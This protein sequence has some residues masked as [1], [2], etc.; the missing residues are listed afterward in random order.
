METEG[1]LLV[2]GRNA[3]FS[4]FDVAS[5]AAMRHLVTF[6]LGTNNNCSSLSVRGSLLFL[7]LSTGSMKIVDLADRRPAPRGVKAWSLLLGGL[8][9]EAMFPIG[10]FRSC[11]PP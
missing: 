9:G 7:A 11:R 8:R 2:V 10:R 6:A 3:Q 4:V 5:P 1:D